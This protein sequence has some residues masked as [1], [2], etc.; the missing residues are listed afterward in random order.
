MKHLL[1]TLLFITLTIFLFSC[2]EGWGDMAK[3]KKCE[4]FNYGFEYKLTVFNP[5]SHDQYYYWTMN[6]SACDCVGLR[7]YEC[8]YILT[9][10]ECITQPKKQ[11][12]QENNNTI[13]NT[14]IIG[15]DSLP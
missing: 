11:T 6:P 4:R 9:Q 8:M 2:R 10:R 3:V 12:N 7:W 1:K 15:R 13:N 5:Q 14:I